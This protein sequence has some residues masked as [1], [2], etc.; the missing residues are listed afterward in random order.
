L[1]LIEH[2]YKAETPIFPN[3][4][5][6]SSEDCH[7]SGRVADV[8]KAAKEAAEPFN[9]LGVGKLCLETKPRSRLADFQL[10]TRLWLRSFARGVLILLHLSRPNTTAFHAQF[11]GASARSELKAKDVFVQD[12]DSN[13]RL[14]S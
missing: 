14:F 9:A 5:E 13:F 6:W 11:T 3:K 12:A 7:L 2:I 1:L 8:P 10:W 4:T